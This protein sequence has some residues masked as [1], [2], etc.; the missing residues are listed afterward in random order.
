MSWSG[1]A[2]ARSS[3]RWRRRRLPSTVPDARGARPDPS[4]GKDVD[5]AADYT[6][7]RSSSDLIS[8]ASHGQRLCLKQFAFGALFVC[9]K[10]LNFTTK[11]L[12]ATTS[13]SVCRRRCCK[14]HRATSCR[15]LASKCPVV[16]G[17][18]RRRTEDGLRS[19]ILLKERIVHPTVQCPRPWAV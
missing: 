7:G 17:E 11:F 15:R 9:F 4:G 2:G 16:P 12:Q 5:R 8:Y 13:R 14:R 10:T 6:A 18:V 19:R 1:S 3:S